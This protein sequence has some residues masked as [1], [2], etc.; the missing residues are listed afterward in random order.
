MNGICGPCMDTDL[1]QPTVKYKYFRKYAKFEPWLNND[2]FKECHFFR[3]D[4]GI[5]NTF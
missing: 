2:D 4:N 3:C 5:A 1:N